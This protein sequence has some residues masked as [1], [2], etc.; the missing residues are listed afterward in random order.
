MG[1]TS[2]VVVLLSGARGK[3]RAVAKGARGSKSRYRSAFEPLSEVRC[4]LYGRQGAELYRLGGCELVRSGFSAGGHDL[5]AALSLCYFAELLDAFS[6]EGEAEPAVFRLAVAVVGALRADVPVPS[7]GRYLEAWLLRL[8]GIYPPLD[9]CS[10][11]GAPLA[12]GE[13]RYDARARGFVCRA[14]EPASGPVLS[15]ATR[16]FLGDVFRKPPGA[17]EAVAP[18]VAGPLE[19]FHQG[20]IGHH[21]ERGLRSHRVLKDVAREMRE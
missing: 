16:V 7:V 8:H 10:G 20:M 19:A 4:E 2:K 15:R 6:L 17:L 9:R 13:L 1:E 14:C 12:Q 11:C 18:E 21:L 3:L 5:D